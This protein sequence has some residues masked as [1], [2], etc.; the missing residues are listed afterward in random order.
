MARRLSKFTKVKRRII[1]LWSRVLSRSLRRY[2]RLIRMSRKMIAVSFRRSRTLHYLLK[3]GRGEISYAARY[4]IS[5][6]RSNLIGIRNDNLK[7][8]LK[9]MM[10]IFVSLCIGAV[11]FIKFVS[12]SI[13]GAGPIEIS[14]DG[15]KIFAQTNIGPGYTSEKQVNIKNNGAVNHSFALAASNIS[16]ELSGNLLLSPV[17]DGNIVWTKT[18]DELSKLPAESATILDDLKP[19]QE[20]IV[21]LKV[22]FPQDA[23]NQYQGKDMSFNAVLGTQEPE[24]IISGGALS[25][26]SLA[27]G[28]SPAPEKL[29]QKPEVTTG[30]AGES[31]KEQGQPMNWLF[32]LNKWL[33]LVVPVSAVVALIIMSNTWQRNIGVPLVAGAVTYLIAQESHGDMA[34]KVFL[35][36]LAIEVIAAIILKLL[37]KDYHKYHIRKLHQKYV[38]RRKLK[39]S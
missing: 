17:V 1:R 39:R 2:Q 14:F 27:K 8:L 12:A 29:S 32:G 36:I 5:H 33:L 23:D 18:F 13:Y 26:L 15:D 4:K 19:G 25:I 34:A 30:K 24:P 20:K 9:P 6:P 7:I 16:G 31:G 37:V 10:I 28:V 3:C 22:E 11:F 38:N 35:M 21:T